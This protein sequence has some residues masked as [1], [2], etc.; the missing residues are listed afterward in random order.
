MPVEPLSGAR[1]QHRVLGVQGGVPVDHVVLAITHLRLH[2][3]VMGS[4]EHARYRFGTVQPPHPRVVT[5]FF[6]L[7]LSRTAQE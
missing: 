5:A 1:I 7:P 2:R 4:V 6:T 3:R